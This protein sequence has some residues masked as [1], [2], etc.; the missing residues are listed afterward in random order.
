MLFLGGGNRDCHAQPA[1]LHHRHDKNGSKQ[2]RWGK[3][4]HCLQYQTL[5][6]W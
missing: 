6:D 1:L 5:F 4:Y 2:Q 3:Y